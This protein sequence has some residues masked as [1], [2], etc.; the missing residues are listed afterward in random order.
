MDILFSI[1]ETGFTR[2]LIA[3]LSSS[4]LPAYSH[5]YLPTQLGDTYITHVH[6]LCYS[7]VR[8]T[9]FLHTSG[10]THTVPTHLFDTYLHPTNI[11]VAQPTHKHTPTNTRAYTHITHLPTHHTHLPTYTP[12]HLPTHPH[13]YLHT[14]TPTYTHTYTPTYTHTHL[15]TYTPTYLHTYL[16]TYTHTHTHTPTHT[17]ARGL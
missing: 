15:P 4:Y 7:T 5:T 12:T 10:D 14:H 8:T 13:T 16:P 2:A 3:G 6:R 11:T 17:C 9:L 1:L